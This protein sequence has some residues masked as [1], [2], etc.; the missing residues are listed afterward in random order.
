MYLNCHTVFSLRYGTL[1]VDELVAEALG[2]KAEVLALTDINNTSGCMDF[3]RA[4]RKSGIK[5]VLGIEFRR[6]KQLQFIALARNK[7]GFQEL[8]RFLTRI[9]HAHEQPPT[10]APRFEAAYVIYPFG[11]K[12]PEDLMEHE[13]VGIRP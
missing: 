10:N 8:N 1:T 4:C 7:A 12:G 13:F 11:R 3:V 9:N 5:P 2:K 6:D